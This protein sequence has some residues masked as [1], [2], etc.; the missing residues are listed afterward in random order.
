[1]SDVATTGVRHGRSPAYP[2][3]S[4][5]KAL[6]RVKALY[7]AEGKHAVPPSSAYK[8]WGIGAKSS[9]ARQTLAALKLFAL[10]TYIGKAKERQVR[11]SDFAVKIIL[12]KRADTSM[13]DELIRRVALN[14]LIYTELWQKYGADLPSDATIETYLLLERDFNENAVSGL[15]ADYKDTLEIAKLS[16][17][18]KMSPDEGAE[19]TPIPEVPTQAGLRPL[20]PLKRR[21][22]KPSM[23]EDVYT[24]KEGDVVFQW[25]DRLSPESYEDLKDWTTLLLRKIARH[26]TVNGAMAT[27]Y[28]DDEEGR[29]AEKHD[30][31]REG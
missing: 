28:T 10:V 17:P 5:R 21:E 9:G 13:R 20:P 29:Q 3:V 12:D 15:I 8:A 24:L 31:E 16:E 7:E 19:L 1:M 14:P 25:P 2:Y 4:L 30:R 11:V 18:D 6:S 23:K 27:E 26:V 22:V